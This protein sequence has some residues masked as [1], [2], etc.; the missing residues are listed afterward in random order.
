MTLWCGVGNTSQ[1]SDRPSQNYVPTLN[2]SSMEPWAGTTTTMT[3][4]VRK[5]RTI[6]QSYLWST[7][8]PHRLIVTPGRDVTEKKK[9][10]PDDDGF[11]LP[12][13]RVSGFPFAPLEMCTDILLGRMF[14]G[15][16]HFL[17]V[18]FRPAAGGNVRSESRMVASTYKRTWWMYIY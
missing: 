16:P 6:V 7:V 18:F 13:F 15:S 1:G 8:T 14:G 4:M 11:L 9:N 5:C 10:L 17:F 2:V 12:S 3:S